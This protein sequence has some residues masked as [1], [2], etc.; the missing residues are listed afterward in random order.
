MKTRLHPIC[1]KAFIIG[2]VAQFALLI[3]AVVLDLNFEPD[4]VVSMLKIPA[5]MVVTLCFGAGFVLWVDA[6]GWL[7]RSWQ[8]RSLP[9]N[10][11]LAVLLV[12]G[13]PLSGVILWRVL[14]GKPFSKGHT[15]F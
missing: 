6:L 14:N 11:C 8:E 3:L 1:Y 9:Q 15:F 4:D 12:F 5:F 10:V 13:Y 7:H 2:V